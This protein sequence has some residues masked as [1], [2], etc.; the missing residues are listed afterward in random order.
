[1]KYK[2]LIFSVLGFLFSCQQGKQDGQASYQ[3][4]SGKTMGTTYHVTYL[5]SLHRNY[6]VPIDALLKNINQE[7]STYIDSAT[8]SKINRADRFYDTEN[9]SYR[10]INRPRLTGL[11]NQFFV[12][13]FLAAKFIHK[14]TNGYFDPTVLP[15]VNYWGFGFTGKKSA[16][17]VDSVLIDS[18]MQFVGFEKIEMKLDSF[19]YKIHKKSAGVQLDF[20]GIAKGYG[21]DAIGWLLEDQGIQS[22]L[23]EIGGEVRARGKNAKGSFWTVG[24]NVPKEDAAMTDFEEI[25][26]LENKSIATSGNYRN[27]HEVEGRKYGHIIN[28]KTGFPERSNLLS[29][30]VFTDDCMMADGYATAFMVMG[31]E[32]S[33]ELANRLQEIE[34]LFIYS[35]EDG[36]LSVRYTS[37][38]KK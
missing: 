15:L 32:K 36:S 38:F 12:D 29:A 19:V 5:D 11:K 14:R 8:I 26:S 13:N 22:Y 6:Q 3:K 37:G 24:I 23:V 21:V 2:I 1:M 33:F 7:V 31:L 34:A 17:K 30:S 25:V 20:S 16:G 27:F 10:L 28:P 4:L 9:D 18:L 35:K